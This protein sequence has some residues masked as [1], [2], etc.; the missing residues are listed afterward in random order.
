MTRAIAGVFAV[1]VAA[2]FAAFFVA[3]RLKNSPS[4]VQSYMASPYFSP[5]RD[6][7]NDRA[8]VRFLLKRA[9]RVTVTIVDTDGDPV[10]ELLS[11]QSAA[12]PRGAREVGRARR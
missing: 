12:L 1:L 3:Q 7:R 9:D 10:R 5:N 2:T 8:V 4:L 11:R 6:G